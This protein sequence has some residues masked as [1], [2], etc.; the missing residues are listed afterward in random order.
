MRDPMT[1]R[2]F[3]LREQFLNIL[4]PEL[5]L[6]IRKAEIREVEEMAHRATV[7]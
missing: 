7:G 5:A 1:W 6:E 3:V 2:E 4:T